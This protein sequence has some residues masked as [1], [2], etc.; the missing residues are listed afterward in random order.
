[1]KYDLLIK[2]GRV[3]LDEGEQEV[4][5]AVK[6]GKIAAIGHDLGDAEK[7]ID[8]KG[9]VVAPGMVDAHV[10]ITEPGGDYR[11]EWEGYETGLKG[12]AKGGV[13]TIVEMPLNQVPATTD[14][15]SIQEKFDAG[16]GKLSADVASY[17]GL[18]PYNLDGG[19]QELDEEGVVAYKAFLATCGDR[20]IDGDFENVDDYSLYEGMKQI[21]K[22]GKIL[23]VHAE[24][25][26]IT[27]R[28]GEIAYKNGEKS[29]A[30]YVDSRPVFTEVEPIR[31]LILFAKETGCRLHIVHVACE[32][33]VDEV[34]KA[35][36]EGVDVT[37]ETCTH[38]LYFYKE[39]LD[40]IGPVVKCSPPIREESRLP[41]MWERVI[42]GYIN[43]V[44]SDHSPST[45]DLKDT[46]NAFE[47]WGGIAGIQNNVDILFDEGV[48]K[49]DLSLKRFAEIIAT[50]PAKRFGLDNKG[51]IAVGKDADF[52]FIK[53]ESSYTLQAEDLEYRNKL[54]PYV[55]RTINAQVAKTILRGEETYSLEDGVSNDFR[56]EFI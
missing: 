3:I 48:Q 34:I 31:K 29:L 49:R 54:S 50:E 7:V 5:V 25:A 55:G 30:A 53:P 40:D 27:D 18:V 11:D 46:D 21:A 45:P 22:T 56:G 43:F 9:Q 24:N 35:Q 32:E 14:R 37:C 8:A 12:A 26:D 39:E 33:G 23:S 13:T 15:A 42:N 44:T 28:L 10:H 51:S 41:G 36:Q 1:M 4:E 6:D 17:G 47:A 16:K 52:V 38:Y 2:N 19:I 20:S